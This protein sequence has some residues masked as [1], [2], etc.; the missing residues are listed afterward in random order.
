VAYELENIES[1][2]CE[3]GL[4][5]SENLNFDVPEFLRDLDQEC[6][7]V[8]TAFKH[9]VVS[10]ENELLV[11][12]YFHFHQESLID[13]INNLHSEAQL[14]NPFRESILDRLSG[15]LN[16]L[17]EHFPDYFNQDVKMPVIYREAIR[18]ELDSFIILISNK[19][20]D[21]NAD[22]GLVELLKNSISV[23]VDSNA[24]ISFRQFYYLKLLQS[25]VDSMDTS[26]RAVFETLDLMRV[27]MHCNFNS[28]PFYNYTLK[29]IRWS[30][31]KVLDLSEKLDQLSY[32]L[33]FSNQVNCIPG[34]AFNDQELPV[35]V[36]VADWI[37]QELMYLKNKQQLMT[38][39][40]AEDV[41]TIDFKLNFDLSVAHLAYLFRAFIESG[42]IQNKSLSE[43]TRFVTKYVKTKRSE[44]ISYESFRIKYYTVESGTKDAVRKVLQSILNSIAKN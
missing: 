1:K 13:L 26:D 24:R 11:K 2:I 34:R 8:K 44:S 10:F 32:Y 31:D 15:L 23:C 43:L 29:Y 5:T 21:T 36:Q 7:K 41:L 28:E 22:I 25:N 6:S 18:R 40:A 38:T 3:I 9:Q 16:Y 35:N 4:A 37:S 33:K 20:E 27:L 30:V 12:R 19:F 14:R 42:V 17:E 39:V